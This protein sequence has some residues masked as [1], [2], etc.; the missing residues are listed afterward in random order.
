[1]RN[2]TLIVVTLFTLAL[3]LFNTAAQTTTLNITLKGIN[4]NV[5]I[6]GNLMASFPITEPFPLALLLNYSS[7]YPSQN[8]LL[9]YANFNMIIEG[10]EEI[11]A[12]GYVN[13]LFN[14][15]NYKGV[16]ETCLEGSGYFESIN[17]TFDFDISL[18]QRTYKME[19]GDLSLNLSVNLPPKSIPKEQLSSFKQFTMLLNPGFVNALLQQYNVTS[20]SFTKLSASLK[21]G[22]D[23]LS[24]DVA[25]K[26]KISNLTLFSEEI[27][28]LISAFSQPPEVITPYRFEPLYTEEFNRLKALSME[29]SEKGNLSLTIGINGKQVSFSFR[30]YDEERGPIKEYYN[31]LQDY[32]VRVFNESLKPFIEQEEELAASMGYIFGKV[33]KLRLVPSSSNLYVE[34]RSEDETVKVLANL[35]DVTVTHT[36][37]KGVEARKGAASIIASLLKSL[38]KLSKEAVKVELSVIDIPG[39]KVDEK[40]VDEII[41]LVTI[42]ERE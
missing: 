25:A 14:F 21:P 1:M 12:R 26:L 40:L 33:F 2:R 38:E 17:G 22:A 27:A 41:K 35:K 8:E 31:S 29:I 34:V 16:S 36:G 24:L 5:L 28:E 13:L 23:K 4:D 20:M 42:K 15:E 37:K 10:K 32:F 39:Y 9:Q 19:K 7:V 3:V 18:L 30:M 11:P 6:S